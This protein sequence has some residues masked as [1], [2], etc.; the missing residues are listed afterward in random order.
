MCLHRIPLQGVYVCDVNGW[1]F[2]KNSKRYYDDTAGILRRWGGTTVGNTGQHASLSSFPHCSVNT[3]S[4]GQAWP[5][6]ACLNIRACSPPCCVTRVCATP[7][8]PPSHVTHHTPRSIM[9][10][11]VAPERLAA[12]PNP[13]IQL[14]PNLATMSAVGSGRVGLEQDDAALLLDEVRGVCCV[15]VVGVAA[16]VWPQPP[17]GCV[18]SGANIVRYK[19]AD[20]R[21]GE[22][23]CCMLA[24]FAGGVSCTR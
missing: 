23:A 21:Y 4:G 19:A 8:H 18:L 5:S 11:A 10:G 12:A 3:K 13:S 15:W 2:V 6:P 9:L 1:S 24:V 16:A 14:A 20:H 22:P 17:V 7:T